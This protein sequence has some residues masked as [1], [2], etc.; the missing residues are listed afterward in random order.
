MESENEMD[1]EKLV[2]T[3]QHIVNNKLS[4][5]LLNK[6]LKY[7]DKCGKSRLQSSLDYY[8][9]KQDDICFKYKASYEVISKIIHSALKSFE[10]SEESFIRAM[11]DDY[12]ELGLIS[13]FKG[14]AKFGAVKPFTPGAP[15]QIVWNITKACNFRCIHCYENAGKKDENELSSEEILDGIDRLAD[16]GVASIAFSG[17][18]PSIHPDIK[19]FIKHA[20]DRGMYVSMATNG[21]IFNNYETAKE[22]SDLGL[23]FVQISLDGL[24]PKT[25]DEFRQVKGSWEHA[26]NAI[27]NFNKTDTFVEVSTTVTKKN[28]DEIPEM[29]DFLADLKVG[30]F[31]LYNFIPTGKGA[32]I[33]EVDLSPDERLEILELIYE[34]NG[35]E[36]MQILST[37]PQFTDVVT[38]TY[39]NKEMIPTHF[40]NVEY[41][42]PAM[43]QLAE[44]V[45]GC[46]A[47]RFYMSVE[48]DGK[49]YPCVFFPHDKEVCLGNIN[50]DLND[51]WLNNELLKV[52]RDKDILE[53][54]CGECESRYICGGCRARA[55][56]YFHDIKYGDP[57]CVKN[58]KEWEEI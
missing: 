5:K 3:F 40:Y 30:W 31:M 29:I 36:D 42:N 57:G 27:K 41:Q 19:K 45:G 39:D 32:D 56:N 22:F 24:N 1:M 37:A 28:K 35:I 4:K 38:H 49:I 9:G 25:H 47:G 33:K 51:L 8:L 12:W 7:C 6:S 10:T 53:G 11:Q 46:G 23:K 54:H 26:V 17:G 14:L 20:T 34:K 2:K 58:M 21:Y 52:F 13:T 15:Y 50:D 55:Y 18:E 16:L 48:P 43:M 44:F